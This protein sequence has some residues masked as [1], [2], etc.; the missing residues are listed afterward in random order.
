MNRW[1]LLSINLIFALGCCA[2]VL[3]Q[4]Y[5]KE[6]LQAEA[7]FPDEDKV[8]LL[9]S[10]DVVIKLV[11]DTIEIQ[12]TRTEVNYIRRNYSLYRKESIYY[13][14]EFNKL[15]DVKAKTL[16][17]K[18]NKKTDFIG[19]ATSMYHSD[20]IFYDDNSEAYFIYPG[21]DDSCITE[22]KYKIRFYEPRLLP[23][24][25]FQF[26]IPTLKSKFSITVPEGCEIG[27]KLNDLG[28]Y[29]IDHSVAERG[30]DKIYSWTLENTRISSHYPDGF[31]IYRVY[32]HIVYWIKM[33]HTPK[34]ERKVLESLKE[35]HGWYHGF[36]KSAA[37]A[38]TFLVNN[39][40]DTITYGLFSDFDKAKAIFNWVQSNIKYVAIEDGY[41]GF[42]PRRADDVIRK[43]YGDCKDMANL[44]VELMRG[45]GLDARHIWIGTRSIS[46]T[47][48]DVHTPIV[49][50]HMIAGVYIDKKFHVLDATGQF[51]PF[52]MPTSFIQGKLGLVEDGES[53]LLHPILKVENELNT[54]V[55]TL[56]IR[57]DNNSL[58]SKGSLHLSGYPLVELKHKLN[59]YQNNG[60]VKYFREL[61]QKGN[62]KFRLTDYQIVSSETDQDK[63]HINYHF[64]VDDYV[65]KVDDELFVNL[66]VTKSQISPIDARYGDHSVVLC[67]DYNYIKQ[68][69][70]VFE[71]PQGYNL[72]YI[73]PDK[74]ISMDFA[75][76][77]CNYTIENNRLI[78]SRRLEINFLDLTREL[79]SDFNAFVSE[80]QKNERFNVSLKTK[81]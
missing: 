13:S 33:Y 18:T 57:V 61:L 31:P 53:F 43:R 17:L 78:Y 69:Y 77:Y 71:I 20:N 59:Y 21:L 11:N 40:A 51:M 76:Y 10:D 22:L 49:D 38:D 68:D 19:Y 47:Y 5:T 63:V 81:P 72:N 12:A 39:L 25:F 23:A 64:M 56:T 62:N 7:L 3:S 2:S 24:F 4:N 44:I 54:V 27:F 79:M 34:H 45:V 80:V 14:T 1:V 60:E 58:V 46:Y 55:D 50:N 48:N 32:P 74:E 42:I 9:K 26:N 6:C 35:L 41:S 15:M 73:P 75:N 29:K 36:L 65:S 70:I 28:K 67:N 30:K 8:V 52:G 66:N 16:N 37:T